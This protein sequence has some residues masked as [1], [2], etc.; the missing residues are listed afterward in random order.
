MRSRLSQ[1]RD[2]WRTLYGAV[3]ETRQLVPEVQADVSQSVTTA[4][5]RVTADTSRISA[6]TNR[7]SAETNRISA[8]TSR[9]SA[10]T[11][12]ISTDAGRIEALVMEVLGR[13][14]A[15]RAENDDIR[16]IVRTE[17]ARLGEMLQLVADQE[18]VQRQRLYAIRET[19]AYEA[20][21]SDD[22]PLVSVVIPTH[23]RAELLRERSIP[24]VLAQTYQNF[25]VIVVAEE[26]PDEVRDAVLGFG[27]DRVRFVERDQRG[28]YPDDPRLRWFVAGVPPY[29]AGVRL[30][31]GAWIAPLD[32]DDAF[33]PD[34]IELLLAAAQREHAELVYGQILEHQLDGSTRTLG[35]F[36]P[37]FAQFNLQ[38]SLY[39]SAI[40]GIFELELSDSAFRV[41]Y[42]WALCR[43]MLRAGVTM[44]MIDELVVDYFPSAQFLPD[45]DT[46]IWADTDSTGPV[47]PEWE[48]VAEGWER[49]RRPDDPSSMGWD[50]EAVATTYAERWPSFRAAIAGPKS[51]G[52]S[53]ELPTGA[54]M[55]NDSVVAHNTALSL[56]YVLS[57]A[58][59]GHDSF[60]VLDWGGA[61]GHQH[62][63][64]QSGLPEVAFDWHVRELPAVCR[65]GRQASPDVTF[66]D[67]D[68]CLERDYDFV[69]ASSSLQYTE[70]WQPLLERLAGAAKQGAFLTR[71]PLVE[72]RPSFV[73]V[74]RAQTYGY[75]TEYVGWV[76]NRSSLL[77][78]ATA[79]G[80][81]LVREFVI[82]EP[83][84]VA[85][86]PERPSLWGF[87]FERTGPRARVDA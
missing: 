45:T 13:A 27:D 10:E 21:F 78:A 29:N 77:D 71:V 68:D 12:R 65:E 31:R 26:A 67:T 48:Y 37:E 59:R 75:A 63:I 7:I 5:D 73:V 54:E 70:E 1:L 47:R 86:A 52:V 23:D 74:Q 84:D 34:H 2:R 16:H 40:A 80:L 33:R 57:R 3:L 38:A 46:E 42:D 4:A 43:R 30:A 41:P 64:A 69:I 61:L 14:D 11:S 51:L 9:I 19:D 32:D 17:T 15:I 76:L 81:E 56:L 53:Y 22:R 36:P 6:E 18:P 55:S 50:V 44:A 87:Y 83:M 66:H 25:E 8:D 72:A 28:P 35:C 58:T 20:A 24:S 62:A 49:T 85:G 79:A 39:H 82:Q 60:S